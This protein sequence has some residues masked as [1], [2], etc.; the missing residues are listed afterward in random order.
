MKRIAI[1]IVTLLGFSILK[2]DAQYVRTKP[3]VS[4]NISVGAPGPAPYRG[5]VWVGPEWQYR[6]GR[7][8]E[9]PGYWANPGRHH[10]WAYGHWKHSRRGY[11]WVPGNWK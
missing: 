6:R 2:A 10:G 5:A 8:V 11:K 1:V 9:V 4:V 3:G 7:Y